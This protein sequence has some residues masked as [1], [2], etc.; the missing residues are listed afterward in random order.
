MNRSMHKLSDWCSPL[1][2]LSGADGVSLPMRHS[3]TPGPSSQQPWRW[4]C[5]A[6]EL[7]LRK[8]ER[9]V[10]EPRGGHSA[11]TFLPIGR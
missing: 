9:A 8:P 1:E 5:S 7:H 2:G 3:K 10:S 4:G 6:W 11:F